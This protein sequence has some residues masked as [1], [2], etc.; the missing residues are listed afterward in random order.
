MV[1]KLATTV[2]LERAL[3][4]I[5]LTLVTAFSVKGKNKRVK[6]PYFIGFFIIA[7]CIGTYFPAYKNQYEV[8]TIVAKKG[9]TLTLFLIGSGLSLSTIK[10]VGVKPLM[11]GVLLWLLISVL[12][13]VSILMACS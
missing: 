8:I 12:S 2:K 13:I 5:P 7:I 3:W 1:R 11:Q 6:L 10:S 4:I 9:L